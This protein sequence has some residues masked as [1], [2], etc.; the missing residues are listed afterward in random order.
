METL[1]DRWNLRQRELACQE[2]LSR[3]SAGGE[4]AK[5]ARQLR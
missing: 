5:E 3:H 2:T 4:D 1:L